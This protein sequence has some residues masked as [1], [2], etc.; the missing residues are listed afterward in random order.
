MLLQHSSDLVEV[1][2]R[3]RGHDFIRDRPTAQ[4]LTRALDVK[5]VMWARALRAHVRQQLLEPRKIG[6]AARDGV[7]QRE[8]GH[9]KIALAQPHALRVVAA[10]AERVVVEV[11]MVV[12][13]RVLS[14]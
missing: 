9:R 14:S 3:H 10:D 2:A 4:L 8:D 13:T 11:G 12:L 5:C 1:H 6:G 7:G